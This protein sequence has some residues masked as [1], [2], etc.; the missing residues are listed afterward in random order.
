MGVYFKDLKLPENCASC[1]VADICFYRILSGDKGY[2]NRIDTC[3]MIEVPTPHGSLIDAKQLKNYFADVYEQNDSQAEER[4]LSLNGICSAIDNVE[5]DH[6][7]IL[8]EE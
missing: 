4:I 2:T 8:P 3:P 6:A 7:L 5:F 1:W